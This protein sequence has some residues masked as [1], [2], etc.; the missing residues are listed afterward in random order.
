MVS[1]W[2]CL[3]YFCVFLYCNHQVHRDFLI[4]L[5]NKHYKHTV[6]LY[7]STTNKDRDQ[8]QNDTALCLT[9]ISVWYNVTIQLET[10]WKLPDTFSI[11][12]PISYTEMYSIGCLSQHQTVTTL[13]HTLDPMTP[14]ISK[15]GHSFYYLPISHKEYRVRETNSAPINVQHFTSLRLHHTPLRPITLECFTTTSFMSASSCQTT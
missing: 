8:T 12:R 14:K 13:L 9:T 3:K 15:K 7:D 10:R 6:L 5:F 2:N 4:A 11:H 1:A